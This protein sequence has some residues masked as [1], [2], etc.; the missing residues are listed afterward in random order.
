MK[1]SLVNLYQDAGIIVLSVLIAVIL[2]Q[3][4][5][6][7]NLLN[8]GQQVEFVG[9]FIA[10]IFFTSVFTAA[11]AVLAFGEIAQNHSLI[12][13][14][15]M[16][17]LGS[18]VGD[19]IIFHF[20]K[21]RFSTH[22]LELIN[23]KGGFLRVKHVFKHRFFHWLTLL[24]GCLIIASPLPDELGISLLGFS[25]TKTSLFALLSFILNFSGILFICWLARAL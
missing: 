15:F 4:G 1:K 16:G 22:I 18:V 23:Q 20:I 21:E 8:S 10:G 2:W 25:K 11:P 19:L 24:V 7:G 12:I 17:G 13:T 5:V 9:S 3:T 6:L 14:A